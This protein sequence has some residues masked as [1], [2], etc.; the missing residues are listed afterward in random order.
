VLCFQSFFADF[1]MRSGFQVLK[2]K[3]LVGRQIYELQEIY[4]LE[5]RSVPALSGADQ[6]PNFG[7]EC[8]ICMVEPKDTAVLPCR[9]MCMCCECAKIMRLVRDTSPICR[10]CVESMVRIPQVPRGGEHQAAPGWVHVELLPPR[11]L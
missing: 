8:V 11:K 9:H 3:V 7:K 5:S 2:Q 10:T 1:L 4:G 6:D